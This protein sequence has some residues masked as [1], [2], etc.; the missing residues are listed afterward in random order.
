MEV[1]DL[2]LGTILLVL[3]LE[4]L[5]GA[6]ADGGVETG[7][8]LSLLADVLLQSGIV[9]LYSFQLLMQSSDLICLELDLCGLL[10]KDTLNITL[11]V[12]HS[13]H[14]DIFFLHFTLSLKTP[15]DTCLNLKTVLLK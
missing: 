9:A 15:L 12:L 7:D 10:L 1:N 8:C 14:G 13:S 2:E 6:V 3:V 11:L 4:G 5:V